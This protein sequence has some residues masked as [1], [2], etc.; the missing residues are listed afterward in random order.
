MSRASREHRE[1]QTRRLF[2]VRPTMQSSAQTSAQTSRHRPT[3]LSLALLFGLVC[4]LGASAAAQP[5]P[6]RPDSAAKSAAQT[7]AQMA[8]Q[9]AAKSAVQP[10]P[11]RPASGGGTAPTPGIAA[12]NDRFWSGAF[13]AAAAGYRAALTEHPFS[14][15]LW[16]NLGCAEAEAG[17]LGAAIHALE[18]AL[19]LV[20]EHT[21]AAHN[22]AVVRARAI[23]GALGVGGELRV[24]RPGEDDLGTGLLTAVRPATLAWLF[25]ACWSVCFALLVLWRRAR[26]AAWRTAASFGAVLTGL[27]ALA[28]GGL[29]VGRARLDAAAAPG[30]VLPELARVRVGPGA[31]Y[32]AALA[33]VGG[34]KV[35]LQ[36]RDGAFVQV[37]LPDGSDGWL[38]DTE[39]APLFLAGEP[40]AEVRTAALQRP[41]AEA[42]SPAR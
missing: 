32:K 20:P 30:V 36:G 9:T 13:A 37:R 7:A 27:G 31:Q 3:R 18:E 22:L 21:D 5:G 42:P 10:G 40:S 16:F 23:E 15:D 29:L 41:T 14:A 25:G 33:V 12:A 4:L 19:A 11:A 39:V 17:R 2:G 28:A 35:Q 24:A 34:V 26:S 1:T 6:T 8:A 38:P